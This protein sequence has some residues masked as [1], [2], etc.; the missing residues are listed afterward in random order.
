MDDKKTYGSQS[1]INSGDE[2]VISGIAGKFPDSDNMNQLRENLFNKVNLV[3]PDHDRWKIEN[4]NLPRYLGTIKNVKK[5]DADFFGFPSQ[6]AHVLSPETRMLLERS[7][8]AII[9]AGINPK[10]LR[11]K[12]TAVIMGITILETQEKFLYEDLQIGGVNI[13]GC[14][15]FATANMISCYL[16]LKGPSYTV[17]TS[18][19]SS[20][21]AVA[22]GFYCIMSGICEDA[23][24]GTAHLC[25]HPFLNMQIAGLGVL[26]FDDYCR[27][28]D[29]AANGFVRSETVGVIY[30]Q[31][32]KNA[33]RIYATCSN[34]KINNN[35]YMEEGILF[36]STF[37][38]STLYKEFYNECKIST[39]CLDY[40]ETHGTA[41]KA[42]DPSEVNAIHNVLCKNRK[43]SLM[44]GSVKSNLG[45]PEPAS[46]IVQIAKVIIAFETGLIPPNIHYTS[47][48]KDIDALFNGTVQVVTEAT[49][50]KNGYIA[51]NSFGFGGSIAHMLLKWNIKQKINNGAPNDDLP[52]LVILSGRTE[53]SVKLFLNDFYDN[54]IFLIV[55]R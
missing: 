35:G 6:E 25:L 21:Y 46:G 49:P 31:K 55:D 8:E 29:I 48:R 43:S 36:P 26:S 18:C 20:L 34:I 38:L 37:M 16:D 10:Q 9:D 30:L 51:I 44:I 45:H 47:P 23:I 15:T 1:D 27:P 7:Y 11:G 33:K 39:S 40:I 14:S 3:R 19:S 41:T 12:N 4:S 22:L 50:V 54:S 53:E 24:I 5:F 32:A 17:D 13:V 2:I 28:F 42:N 52:R